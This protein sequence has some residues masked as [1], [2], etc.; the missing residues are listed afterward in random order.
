[1]TTP[2]A[3]EVSA[4]H[5]AIAGPGRL[6]LAIGSF[7]VWIFFVCGAVLPQAAFFGAVA[8]AI[9]AGLVA[10]PLVV[11]LLALATLAKARVGAD[12]LAVRSFGRTR[13]IPYQDVTDLAVDKARV[14]LRLRDGKLYHFQIADRAKPSVAVDHTIHPAATR[15]REGVEDARRERAPIRVQEELERGDKSEQAW[16]Q[17]IAAHA[18]ERTDYRDAPLDR[19]GLEALS[20]DP[21]ADPTARVASALVLRKV[22]LS[23]TEKETLHEAAAATAHPQVRVALEAVA[24]DAREEAEV[25]EAVARVRSRAAR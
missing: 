3:I 18:E 5:P 20:S 15:I 22:G 25:G 1:M 16:L 12:G 23:H 9:A 17:A 6:G 2:T 11:M 19:E 13:F 7:L 21:R 24:D 4:R 10:A 14:S 8:A